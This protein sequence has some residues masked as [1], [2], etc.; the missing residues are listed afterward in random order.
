MTLDD[1][2][3][4]RSGSWDA[5]TYVHQMVHV[6]QYGALGPDGFLSAYFGTAALTIIE[7]WATG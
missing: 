3:F 1:C 4:V 2:V 7:R 6:G 5:N